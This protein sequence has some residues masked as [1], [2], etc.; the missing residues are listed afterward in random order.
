MSAGRSK[1]G[2]FSDFRESIAESS[3]EVRTHQECRLARAVNL[4]KRD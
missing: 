2:S 4:T 1:T 3:D